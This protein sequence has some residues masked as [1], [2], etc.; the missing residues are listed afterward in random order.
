MQDLLVNHDPAWAK[1]F[2]WDQEQE[3]NDLL[4][5]RTGFKTQLMGI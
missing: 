2:T 4:R 3:I 5:G 1:N